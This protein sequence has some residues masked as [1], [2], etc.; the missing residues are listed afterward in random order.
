M[1]RVYRA[2]SPTALGLLGRYRSLGLLSLT[3]CVCRVRSRRARVARGARQ[4]PLCA[5]NYGSLD[6]ITDLEF[7]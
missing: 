2:L 5:F 7:D 4:F 6:E 3:L 1:S